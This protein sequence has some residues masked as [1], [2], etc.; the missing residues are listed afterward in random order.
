M[1]QTSYANLGP[2][3]YQAAEMDLWHDTAPFY[4]EKIREAGGQARL[5]V[6][7]GVVQTWWSM[8]PELSI[9]RKWIGDLVQGVEWLLSLKRERG[10]G[11]FAKL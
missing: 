10:G 6:Y 7:K 4:C 9:N 1:T 8:Y 5:D 11:A 3:Y 2:L